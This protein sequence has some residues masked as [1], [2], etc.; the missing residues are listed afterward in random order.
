M[1][2]GISVS[3]LV[4][5]FCGR[6]GQGRLRPT[7]AGMLLLQE[8]FIELPD[9]WSIEDHTWSDDFEDFIVCNQHEDGP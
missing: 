7:E 5:C 9:G 6:E 2:D 8:G 4:R 3:L 1:I